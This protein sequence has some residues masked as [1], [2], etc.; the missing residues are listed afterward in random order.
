MVTI[1]VAL[2]FLSYMLFDPAAWLTRFM[3]LTEMSVDFRFF[4]L[5]LGAIY[6]CM[7][8]VGEKVIFPVLSR[9]MGTLMRK[10]SKTPKQRKLYKL[11]QEQLRI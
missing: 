9:T 8:W 6:I 4:I 7:A 2:L 5:A 3:Q 1:V 11:V 10:A